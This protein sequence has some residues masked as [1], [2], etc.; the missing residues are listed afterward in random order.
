VGAL[1]WLDFRFPDLNWAPAHAKLAV[2]QAALDV[3][4]SFQE[5]A[6]A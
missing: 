4:P 3:R 6:P 2:L 5:T 1:T